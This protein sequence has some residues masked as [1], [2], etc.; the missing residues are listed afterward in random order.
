TGKTVAAATGISQP[1]SVQGAHQ[2]IEQIV[3]QRAF[4]PMPPEQGNDEIH[5][6]V[7]DRTTQQLNPLGRQRA[8]VAFDDEANFCLERLRRLTQTADIVSSSGETGIRPKTCI[9]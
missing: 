2:W 9:I 8:Q 7:I 3:H 1:L 6:V 4:I 5:A